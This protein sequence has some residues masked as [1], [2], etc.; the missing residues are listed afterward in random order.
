VNPGREG[1]LPVP[2]GM[3]WYR[4][5]G[6]GPGLPLLVLHG[7]PGAGSEY[8][9]VLGALG[10]ERTVV[11]YDQLGGGRSEA[12][13]LPQLWRPERFVAELAAVRRMLGL[14]RVHLFGH[15]WGGWLAIDYL[16]S[17]PDGVASVTLASTSAS[18]AEQGR[19]LAVLRA[20]LPSEL[21]GALAE[22]ETR[23][24]YDAPAYR[25]ALVEF[26]QRHLCRLPVWPAE[27]DRAMVGLADS[28]V[29]RTML[30][31][32]E[33]V[34]TGTL[35]DWDCTAN[36]ARIGAPA[37]VTVGRFD[38]IT[39][40]CAETLRRALPDARLRVFEGSA[41]MPHLEEPEPYLAELAAF[42]EACDRSQSVS[43]RSA[44]TRS[45]STQSAAPG[46]LPEEGEAP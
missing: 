38:E 18:L 40:A 43:A 42:L 46:V 28:A 27:L 15:S 26:Y 3:V 1:Y 10:A 20:A 37:L 2:G 23:E 31:P 41:H 11:F 7:G 22:H 13:D 12:P 16:L 32:N 24:E 35:R 45:A 5:V 25:A 44:S 30:G 34:L 9:H 14:G 19:E 8:L 39:P 21:A 6:S 17:Q 4:T 29:Y 33:L 36:L